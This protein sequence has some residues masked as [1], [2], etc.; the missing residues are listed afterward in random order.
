MCSSPDNNP[1]M[2]EVDDDVPALESLSDG[3]GEKL[4]TDPG[5]DATSAAVGTPVPEEDP[6]GEF[7]MFHIINQ[8]RAAKEKGRDFSRLTDQELEAVI[9]NM[10]RGLK[11]TE[12]VLAE[13]DEFID[14]V[15]KH[16]ASIPLRDRIICLF[17][18][19]ALENLD[20]ALSQ[21][22]REARFLRHVQGL[23]QP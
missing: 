17:H 5:V 6:S 3:E 13:Y 22:D 2:Q 19:L 1:V 7:N 14:Y 21:R 18:Q 23:C 12:R 8:I 16:V 4:S 20:E 15:T 10:P 9:A 11:R